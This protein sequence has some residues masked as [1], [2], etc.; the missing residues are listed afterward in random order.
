MAFIPWS[1]EPNN[2]EMQDDPGANHG[3]PSF[4][5]IISPNSQFLQEKLT[6]YVYDLF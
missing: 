1:F 5:G 3:I 6:N 2:T 4:H